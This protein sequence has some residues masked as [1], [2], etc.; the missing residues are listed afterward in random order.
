MTLDTYLKRDGAKALT[1]LSIEM[2]VSKARLSQLRNSTDWP[3]DLAL[4][5]EQA[6]KGDI[7]ASD[8]SHVIARARGAT[9]AP[10]PTERAA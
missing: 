4:R 2:G 9:P 8:L 10:E 5:V 6:T 7:S 3:P 1:A